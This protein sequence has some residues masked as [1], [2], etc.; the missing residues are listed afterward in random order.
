[1]SA[2]DLYAEM[3]AKFFLNKCVGPQL[4]ENLR[5]FSN[6]EL[7]YMQLRQINELI[8]AVQNNPKPSY[9]IDGQKVHWT[10]YL[11]MLYK[12]RDRLNE[13]IRKEE[14]PCEESMEAWT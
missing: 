4:D 3:D 2:E 1:M 5:S 9:D 6:L 11:D 10:D 12:N 14:G 13:A 8:I 7:L